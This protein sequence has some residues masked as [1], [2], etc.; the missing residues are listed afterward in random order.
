MSEGLG[1]C[2]VAVS[3]YGS[4][5]EIEIHFLNRYVDVMN[6]VAVC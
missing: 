4:N 1:H 3:G 6:L 2:R 5:L